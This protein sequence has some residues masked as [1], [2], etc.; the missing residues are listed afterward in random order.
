MNPCN[1]YRANRVTD[2]TPENEEPVE[3]NYQKD[4]KAQG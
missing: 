2:L 4:K 3:V 1:L